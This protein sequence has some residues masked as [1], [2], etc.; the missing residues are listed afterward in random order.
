MRC[1]STPAR[2]IQ[3]LLYQVFMV[4]FQHLGAIV[5]IVAGPD[6]FLCYILVLPLGMCSESITLGRFDAV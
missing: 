4:Y 5:C 3:L 6:L 1:C 2:C